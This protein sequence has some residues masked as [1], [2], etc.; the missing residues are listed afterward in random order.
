[1]SILEKLHKLLL[2][3]S[4]V[5]VV[6]PIKASGIFIGFFLIVSLIIAL[7]NKFKGNRL[8]IRFGFFF[9]G[10][11]VLFALGLFYTE[12]TQYGYKWLERNIAWFLIPL[13]IPLSLKISR[14]ELFRLLLVF[15]IAIQAI[16][17]MLIGIAIWNYTETNDTLVFYYDQLTSVIA[18]HPVYF[19][20]YV[21]FSL[22][23]VVEG[24]RKKY[25][26]LRPLFI[27]SLVLFDIVLI[28]L[29][30]SKTMLAAL[31]LMLIIFM[32]IHYKKQRKILLGVVLLMVSSIVL[33]TQFSE[34][35]NR[36]NDSVF[37]SWELL[38]KETFNYNDPFTG[39]TLRLITWK[40]VMKKFMNEENIMIGLGTGDAEN[41]INQVYTERN[42]D[43]AGYLNFNMHNQYLEYF[44]KFGLLGVAYFFI[45]LFL[46]F[47][48]AIRNKDFLYGAFLLIFSIF[49]LTESTLEVQKGILFFVLVNTLFIFSYLSSPKQSNE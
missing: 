4:L 14:R 24:L 3:L 1:M 6:L 7:K 47:R 17:I 49:S 46:S 37:S 12:E 30:S 22:L 36:V 40:F 43:D 28:V 8:A 39:I 2:V 41:F 25:V 13:L 42:M 26:K 11:F 19:S 48:M 9:A 27:V 5:G 20:L 18:F 44:L 15:S 45:I 21:L 35:K 16:G 34:T 23:I 10:F 29:L 32:I 31:F 33:I 38:D